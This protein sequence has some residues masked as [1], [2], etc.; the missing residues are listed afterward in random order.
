MI[1]TERVRQ[2]HLA[3]YNKWGQLLFESFNAKEGWNGADALPG[4]YVWKADFKDL[5]GEIYTASWTVSL[6]R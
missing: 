1:D 5:R 2:F 4:V 3:I 6:M